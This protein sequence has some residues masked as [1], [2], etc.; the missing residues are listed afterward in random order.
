MTDERRLQFDIAIGEAMERA[1]AKR[2]QFGVDDCALWV[3]DIQKPILGY[4]PAKLVRGR[5]KTRLGSLRVT[6]VAGLLGQLKQIARRHRWKRIAP[7]QAQAGDTGLVWTVV[8]VPAYQWIKNDEGESERVRSK[9]G[10]AVLAT[11]ICR[12]P[13]WFVGRNEGGWTAIRADKVAY[14]WSVFDDVRVPTVGERVS[15]PRFGRQHYTTSAVLHEPISTA[16]GLTDLII[17]AFGASAAVA[18]A[19]G[20]AIVSTGLAIGVSLAASLLR[21]SSG[22]GIG[23]DNSI[24]YSTASNAQ[25]TERQAIPYKRIIVGSAY[26]GGA[27]FYEQVDNPLLTQGILINYGK[28]AGFDGITIGTNRLSFAMPL[29]ENVILSPIAVD[30]QPNYPNRLRVSLRLGEDDQLLDTLIRQGNQSIPDILG[31]TG[32]PIGNMTGGGGIA[33]GFDGTVSKSAAA[34][35]SLTGTQNIATLGKDWGAGVTKIVRTFSF[36][37]P[38]NSGMAL[39][40]TQIVVTLEGSN[41]NFVSDIHTLCTLPASG[42]TSAGVTTTISTGVDLSTGYRAH[43]LKFAEQFSA[44]SHALAVAQITFGELIDPTNPNFRQRGN[45]TAVLEYNYGSNP[46]E[47]V[48]LWGQVQRPSA[49]FNVRGVVIYDPRDPTQLQ[50]DETT[51]KWSNNAS[52][53]QAWYMTRSFGGRIPMEKMRWDKIAVSANY[54]DE[55]IGCLDG[56]MIK[57]HTIDGVITLN[58]APPDVMQQLLTANRAQLLESAGLYWIES[59]RPKLPSFTIGDKMLA[60]GIT[61]QAARQKSDLVNK[62]QVRFVSPDQDYQVVDGPIFSRTDLQLVD[63]EILPATLAL[64][65]TLDYRRAERLQKLFLLSSRIG[66]T[67]TVSVDIALMSLA[68]DELIGSVCTFYSPVLFTNANGNYMVTAVGFSDDCTTLSL[69]LT[70]YDPTIE[71]GW[72]PEVDETPFVIADVFA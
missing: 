11:A 53:I 36:T 14:A 37:T 22:S 8:E 64:N 4:D 51:W 32:A 65:Y 56:T 39:S 66:R 2:M 49:Y 34:S 9:C 16:I 40:L 45:A 42:Y 28:I 38:N 52:L 70:E 71:I 5:Y 57:R 41:D 50:S 17:G 30:G 61:Y 63:G 23:S 21:P 58:Q 12:A 60:S 1:A 31:A 6:G 43:R 25:I 10:V 55:L 67:I 24:S 62:L 72:N 69:A 19:I 33:A 20:G 68:T 15:L 35:A 26:V 18:G 13:G 59:S 27:L 3:A 47:F 46:T 48:T 54:D 7:T 44:T 29:T